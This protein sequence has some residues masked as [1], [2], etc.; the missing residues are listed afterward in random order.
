MQQSVCIG[1]EYR[2]HSDNIR[3]EIIED[4]CG[5]LSPRGCVDFFDNCDIFIDSGLTGLRNLGNT[6]YMNAALQALSNSRAFVDYFR[7][8]KVLT[9]VKSI[10]GTESGV[11]TAYQQLVST[12][13]SKSRIG[14]ASAY[15][16]LTV[17]IVVDNGNRSR[18]LFRQFGVFVHNFVDYRNKMHKNLYDVFWIYYIANCDSL[19]TT[20]NN[21]MIV[22]RR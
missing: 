15:R 8:L 6:C 7:E 2:T 4:E 12:M 19:Y 13:W 1:R 22:Y 20:G 16:L 21:A 10:T 9:D 3:Q 11:V 18:V 14:H 17:R 5:D